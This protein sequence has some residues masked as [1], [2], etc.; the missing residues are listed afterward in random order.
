MSLPFQL[1]YIVLNQ[2]ANGTRY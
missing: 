2:P 1:T